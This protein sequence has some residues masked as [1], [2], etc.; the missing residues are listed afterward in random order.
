VVFEIVS[1][2]AAA[3]WGAELRVPAAHERAVDEA[4]AR[5]GEVPEGEYFT[6]ATRFDVLEQVHAVMSARTPLH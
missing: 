5:M 3:G 1:G 4:V 2:E 6:L